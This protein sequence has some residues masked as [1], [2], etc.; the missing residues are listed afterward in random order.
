MRR[1]AA[2]AVGLGLII[3]AAV[4]APAANAGTALPV[5]KAQPVLAMSRTSTCAVRE[6]PEKLATARPSP[7]ASAMGRRTTSASRSSRG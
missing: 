7:R 3:G 4:T 5:T 6:T 1:S 2:I